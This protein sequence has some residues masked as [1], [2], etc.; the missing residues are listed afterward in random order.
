M[1]TVSPLIAVIAA[2]LGL[3]FVFGTAANRLRLPP[4]V[5]YL[6]AGVAVGPFTPGF[7]LD[8]HL[9]LQLA[10]IGVVLLMFG[11]GLHFSPRDLLA[12]KHIVVPGAVIQMA[13]VAVL[14]IG[15]L[16]LEGVKGKQWV[17]VSTHVPELQANRVI[18]ITDAGIRARTTP[19]ITE[20]TRSLQVTV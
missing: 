17:H 3:A 5:G 7:H 11:V 8:Q 6:L 13:L 19:S 9:T 18:T 14:G 2:G 16:I 4:L 20:I 12:V 10:D 1:E 15:Q